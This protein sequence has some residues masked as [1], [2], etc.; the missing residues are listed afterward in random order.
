MRVMYDVKAHETQDFEIPNPFLLL[1]GND[2]F[3]AM[4]LFITL[5][6]FESQTAAYFA[7][8]GKC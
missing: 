5:H 6:T 3:S 4:F 2:K 1:T 8:K 7:H